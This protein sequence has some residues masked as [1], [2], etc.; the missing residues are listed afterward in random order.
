MSLL[1]LIPKLGSLL[2]GG[3]GTVSILL[4]QTPVKPAAL[5]P[6]N[7]MIDGAVVVVL[8]GLALFVICRPSNRR[9]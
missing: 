3:L 7:Y 2:I 5:P 8:C 1:A 6:K 9:S 4:A